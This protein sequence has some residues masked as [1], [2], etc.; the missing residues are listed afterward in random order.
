KE[1]DDAA[2]TDRDVAIVQPIPAD[3]TYR[4]LVRDLH[5]HGGM[6]YVYRMTLNE[7]QND[8]SLSLAA[9]S[10]VLT[11]GKPLEIPITVTRS[12]VNEEIEITAVDLPDGVLVTPVKSEGKGATA[13]AV[14]LELKATGAP[15]SGMVRIVGR[16]L[17]E[18]P[19]ERTATFTVAGAVPKQ[20]SVWLTVAPKE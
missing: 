7:A 1:V 20:S 6:R 5:H 3:G 17:G 18:Q 2:R 10:F 9:Q 8:L 13:K 15:F 12:G 11:P 14:K 4:L 19:L 16:T